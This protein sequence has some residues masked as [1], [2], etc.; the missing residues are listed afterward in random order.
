MNTA[1][2]KFQKYKAAAAVAA[3]AE[4]A[5][6][7]PSCTRMSIVSPSMDQCSRSMQWIAVRYCSV[8]GAAIGWV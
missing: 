6:V 2:L 1:A 3:A 7:E 8:G 5:P 4:S